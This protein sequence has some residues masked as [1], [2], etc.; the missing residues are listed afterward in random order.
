[1]P[2]KTSA[3]IFTCPWPGRAAQGMTSIM[4]EGGSQ[5]AAAALR[6]RVVDQVMVYV[7]PSILGRGIGAVADLGIRKVEDA[8]QLEEVETRR[9]GSDI[10]YTAKVRYPCSQG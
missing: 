2:M 8:I 1:M 9:L 7:A 5:L 3:S 10:L 4:I 6:D